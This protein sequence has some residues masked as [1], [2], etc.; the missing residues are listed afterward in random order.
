MTERAV[1]TV[2]VNG[3]ERRVPERITVR[4]LL[5]HIG[6]RGTAAV[7]R[8]LELVPRAKHAT[9]RVADGDR[10]EVVQLVGGG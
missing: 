2:T 9:E 4:E 6:V 8:N 3:E 1:I 7:E 10:F 5:D